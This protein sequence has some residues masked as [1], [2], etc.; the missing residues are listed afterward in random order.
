M[1]TKAEAKVIDG[2]AVA[3]GVR[4]RVA[5][6]VT[7]LAADTLAHRRG[8]RLAVDHRGAHEAFLRGA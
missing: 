1:S 8:D 7:D 5:G 3:A 4:E 2:K 6:E